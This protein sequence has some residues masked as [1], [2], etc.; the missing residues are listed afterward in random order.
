M[1]KFWTMNQSEE[2]KNSAEITIYGSI[3]SSWWDES[4]SASQFS[5]DL[6][7]LGNDINEI[8]VRINSTGGSVYDGLAI[9]SLLKNHKAYVTVIVDGLAASIASIIAMAADKLIMAKGS[10]M[11]IHNP[12]SGGWGE[13]KD[14]REIADFLDKI[15]DSLVSVYAARTGKTSEELIELLDAETWMSAEEAVEMGFADE[16][17]DEIQVTAGIAGTIAV[18]NGVSMDISKYTNIPDLQAFKVPKI[19]TSNNRITNNP[20][21]EENRM[22]LETIKNDYPELYNQIKNEGKDEGIQSERD[23]IKAIDDL[24]MVGYEDIINKA[25]YESGI[26]AEFVALEIVKADKQ[27]SENYL[28]NVLQ[29]AQP[30]N[31]ID[32][33]VAPQNLETEEQQYENIGLEIANIANAKRGLVK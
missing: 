11:M 31:Q 24:S 1:K 10:M 21:Q 20:G 17:E 2:K 8:T 26:T 23:R 33:A 13:A 14:L 18:V 27:R 19:P 16:V 29:D 7:E 32:G 30:L 3:G 25:K 4:V 9:R 28:N 22:D 15:R 5:K 6:K 12:L